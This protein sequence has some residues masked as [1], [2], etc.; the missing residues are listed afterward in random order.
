M[1]LKLAL[2]SQVDTSLIPS[3]ELQLAIS[4]TAGTPPMGHD[5]CDDI[6]TLPET[7][8]RGTRDLHRASAA[9]RSEALPRSPD[10]L[11]SFPDIDRFPLRATRSQPRMLRSRSSR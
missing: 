4:N 5:P 11:T 8:S 6:R 7:S 1:V 10:C 2:T 9:A 3:T